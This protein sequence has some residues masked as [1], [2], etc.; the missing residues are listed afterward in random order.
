MTDGGTESGETP[1]SADEGYRGLPGA[2]PYAARASDSWLFR[3]YVLIGG[4][5]TAFVAVG[6]TLAVVTILGETVAASGGTF[7]LLRGFYVLVG[8]FVVGPLVAPV[9]VVARRHRR[10]AGESPA[11]RYDAAMGAAGF[12]FLV[13]TY[14]GLVASIPARFVLDGEVVTRTPPE[15]LLAP[16][17]AALYAVPPAASVLF[18]LAGAALLVVVHR[19]AAG[20]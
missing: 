11:P 8:L 20:S 15:G 6:M 3:A 2:Y 17:V 16:V 19:T 5:A 12:C 7:T 10:T 4:A 9:L 1:A 14:A 13:S 18:P